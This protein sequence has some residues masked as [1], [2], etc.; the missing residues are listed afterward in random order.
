MLNSRLIRYSY[1]IIIRTN[2]SPNPFG[3]NPSGLA[4]IQL[5]IRLFKSGCLCIIMYSTH[6]QQVEYVI[7]TW[8]NP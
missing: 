6:Y 5:E 7:L 3:I 4:K 8:E 2:Y 1:S